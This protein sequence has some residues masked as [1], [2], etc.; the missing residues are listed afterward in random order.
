LLAAPAAVPAHAQP[1]PSATQGSPV[2]ARRRYILAGSAAAVVVVIAVVV[3]ALSL[4]GGGSNGAGHGG[5]GDVHGGKAAGADNPASAGQ[6][7]APGLNG[8]SPQWLAWEKAP[9]PLAAGATTTVSNAQAIRNVLK[10]LQAVS[11]AYSTGVDE[12]TFEEICGPLGIGGTDSLPTDAPDPEVRADLNKAA[13]Y[14]TDFGLSCGL[15]DPETVHEFNSAA[16][17]LNKAI[18]RIAKLG[19]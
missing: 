9:G 8:S 4:G 2:G 18:D 1:T 13:D 17:Y 6:G 19:G 15:D 10:D 5:N 3:A 12:T 11:H 7:T 14:L 16:D